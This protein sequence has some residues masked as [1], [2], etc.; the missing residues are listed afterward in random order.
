[1]AY[2]KELVAQVARWLELGIIPMPKSGDRIV[3]LGDQELN[4]GMPLN[5]VID[6]I[7]TIKSDFDAGEI[8]AELPTNQFGSVYAYEMWRRCGLNYLS[9][10]ITEAPFSRVFDLNFHAVPAEDRQTA[11]ILTNIGTTEHVANQL[12][13][14]QTVHDLLKIG[15]VAIHSVPFAGMLNHSLFNY[16]PKF[17]FSLVVNNRY[18]LLDVQFLGPSRHDDLGVGNTVYDGDYLISSPNLQGS[19]NWARTPLCSGVI[20]LAIERVFPD[21]FVPPID[22]AS[23]YFGDI[24]TGDLS[25]LVKSAKLP[26]NAWADAYRR[27]TTPSQNALLSRVPTRPLPSEGK[28]R[29]SF[30]ERLRG[31]LSI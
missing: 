31:L 4:A 29:P 15:G 3:E 6:L 5:V 24:P 1:M 13:A 10:D 11:T 26:H 22:F 9:Y 21:D 14:F 7:K 25:A 17:F 27:A 28:T 30:L 20:N 12:N 19:E 16:H 8:A 2:S 23:G 18:R